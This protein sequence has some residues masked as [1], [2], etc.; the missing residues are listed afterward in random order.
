MNSLLSFRFL[1]VP[2]LVSLAAL[3]VNWRYV[4][5]AL[6]PHSRETERDPVG[7]SADVILAL[8]RTQTMK[9]ST[10]A[11]ALAYVGGR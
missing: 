6:R 9:V 5:R 10:E 7:P 1:I 3:A 4:Y 11:E 2:A 8:G